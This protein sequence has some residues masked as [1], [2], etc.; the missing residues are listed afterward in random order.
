M[1]VGNILVGDAGGH[2]KHDDTTLA[3]DVVAITETAKLLLASGVP[4][5]EGDVAEVLD[6][7]R[8]FAPGKVDATAR[9][10]GEQVDLRS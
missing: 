4:D 10:G 9:C 8:G 6:M 5:V 7:V 2:I 1:P 3:V